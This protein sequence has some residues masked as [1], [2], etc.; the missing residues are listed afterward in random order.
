M[1]EEATGC[2]MFIHNSTISN[3]NIWIFSNNVEYLENWAAS[4]SS[5]S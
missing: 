5:L 3:F 2:L 4:A 1:P